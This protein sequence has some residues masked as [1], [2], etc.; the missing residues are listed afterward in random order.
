MQNKIFALI[1]SFLVTVTV[2]KASKIFQE[3]MRMELIQSQR[4]YS[5]TNSPFQ[6]IKVSS[7]QTINSESLKTFKGK[8]GLEFEYEWIGKE[9]YI[10]ILMA[11]VEKEY[12]PY[13]PSSK[14][15]DLCQDKDYKNIIRTDIL[16]SLDKNLVLIARHQGRIAGC[17]I[18]NDYYEDMIQGI[19]HNNNNF[20]SDK[21]EI[22]TAFFEDLERPFLNKILPL[23]QKDL[24]SPTIVWTGKDYIGNGVYN[25]M[26]EELADRAKTL[27][28]R[29]IMAH[30]TSQQ[31]LETL[32]KN[33]YEIK[34]KICYKNFVYKEKMPF[35]EEDS[36]CWLVVKKVFE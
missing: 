2:A 16:N 21:I 7:L 20:I 8:K 5:K 9:K 23:Q 13:E 12:I 33:R 32:L 27:G 1:V 17:A 29:Y 15:M 6:Q 3:G 11:E 10:D 19:A 36:F 14:I 22:Y 30:P 18:N 24:L 28:Y 25:K 31:P 4:Y 34:N 26:L 35:S